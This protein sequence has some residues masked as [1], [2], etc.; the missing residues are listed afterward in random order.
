MP[1]R[2]IDDWYRFHINEKRS[3]NFSWKDMM[4][5]LRAMKL[6][7]IISLYQA[8]LLKLSRQQ[9]DSYEALIESHLAFLMNPKFIAYSNHTLIDMH[10]LAALR[11]I[12]SDSRGVEIDNFLEVIIPKLIACQFNEH[13]VHLENSCAYQIFGIQCIKRLKNSLWFQRFK[14]DQ[15]LSKANAVNDWFKMPDGRTIPIGDTNGAPMK[16]M[17]TT[18]FSAIH[19]LFNSSGY[20]IYRDDGGGKLD[21]SSYVFL[22]VHSILASTSM[23]MIFLLH[24]SRARTSCAMQA[25]VITIMMK[26]VDMFYPHLPII[27]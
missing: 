3:T 4:V 19:E 10:G 26:S 24:G 6:A 23:M 9:L 1:V 14:L 22:W 18:V 11:S 27:Q 25:S 12:I 15:L 13:G 7:Y 20:V 5:G 8:G 2:F 16:N 21:R 17:E